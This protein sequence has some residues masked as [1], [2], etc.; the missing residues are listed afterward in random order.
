MK[1]WIFLTIAI[2]TEVFATASLASSQG[3]TKL[4]PSTLAVMGYA[5]TFY[6]LSLSLKAIPVGIADAI[7]AGLGV[8]LVAVVGWLRFGQKL[9]F[10]AAIGMAFI[11]VGVLILNLFSKTIRH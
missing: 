3:F 9:D 7:W 10:A 8:V 2:A 6:F 1:N 11:V 4:T 5:I